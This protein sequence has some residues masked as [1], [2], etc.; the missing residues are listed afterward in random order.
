[1]TATQPV[2]SAESLEP[3]VIDLTD[4]TSGRVTVKFPHR[5]DPFTTMSPAARK[6]L[7]VR[8]LC[9]LVAYGEDV[10]EEPPARD[11]GPGI[12]IPRYTR[13]PAVRAPALSAT[14]RF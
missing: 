3:E 1:M 10:D 13:P 7:L 5:I 11:D 2:P 6:R 12:R 9:E 14:T 8:V 4:G